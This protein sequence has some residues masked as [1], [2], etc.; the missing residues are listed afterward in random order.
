MSTVGDYH[1]RPTRRLETANLWVEALATAGPRIVR[2]G[3]AGSDENLLAETP[4]DGWETPFGRYELFGGHRLWY[5]PEDPERGAVPDVEGLVLEDGP[6]S[7][8]LTGAVEAP[9]GLVRTIAIDVVPGAAALS[10]CHELCN[11]G[12]RPIELAPWSIT[13]LPLGGRVVLPQP[14]ARV[15]HDVRPNRSLVL[16]PYTSW[17]DERLGLHDGAVVIDAVPGQDLKIGYFNDAG[18]VAYVHRDTA[19][20]RRFEPARGATHPDLGCNVETYSGPRYL[21]LEVLGPLVTLSPGESTL[22]VE[23]WELVPAPVGRLSDL[24]ALAALLAGPPSRSRRRG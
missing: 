23:R 16:W 9:T 2:L 13:Q 15:G 24:A 12:Q 10:V 3:R 8:R 22:L 17:T 20:V 5:A 14:T 6:D 4:D 18:W 21:E 1:G 11:A 7:L 19:L